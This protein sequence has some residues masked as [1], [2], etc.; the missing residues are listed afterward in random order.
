M[1]ESLL[2]TTPYRPPAGQRYVVN[3]PMLG[4]WEKGEVIQADIDLIGANL[5]ALVQTGAITETEEPRNATKRADEPQEDN[6][7]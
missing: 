5:A 4:P 6:P 7:R 2:S 1:F 3:H